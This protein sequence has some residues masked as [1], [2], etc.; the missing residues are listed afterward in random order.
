MAQEP[1]MRDLESILRKYLDGRATAEETAFLEKYYDYLQDQPGLSSL[2]PEAENK[3]IEQRNWESLTAKMDQPVVAIPPRR[4]PFFRKWGWAAAS[5]ILLLSAGA[6]LWMKQ[7]TPQTTT[8][9]SPAVPFNESTAYIRNITLPDGSTVVLQ[10]GSRLEVPERFPGTTR[11]VTLTGEAYFDIARLDRQ[12]FIIHTGKVKT[13]VLGTAF[14]IKAYPGAEN[15]VVSVTRGKVKV[16]DES[17]LLAELTKNEQITYQIPQANAS[18]QEVD[19]E[20]V[21]TDWTKTDMVFRDVAF[22]Q[23]AATISKRYNVA[24]DFN[25]PA[26]KQCGIVASFSGTETLTNVLETIATVLNVQYSITSNRVVFDGS[27]CQ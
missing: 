5:V 19:A 4:V 25:N 18:K 7:Q 8:A 24:I 1:N 13:T 23:V 20:T 21:V 27:G 26:L 10:A 22:E 14:N 15:I 11:E 12:P 16:E 17:K 2:L 9:A 6:Y 3:R